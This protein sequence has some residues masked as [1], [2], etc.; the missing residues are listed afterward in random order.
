MNFVFPIT[1]KEFNRAVL[2][3]VEN[4]EFYEDCKEFYADAKPNPDANSS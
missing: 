1:E 4:T 3:T 2:V